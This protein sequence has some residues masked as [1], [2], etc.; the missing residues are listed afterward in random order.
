[1]VEMQPKSDAALLREYVEHG[2]EAPL[3]EIAARHTDLVY[4]AAW[5]QV[6]SPDWARDV[7]QGVFTDLVRKAT[8]LARKANDR[9]SLAGWLYGS[10]R[11]AALI[12]KSERTYVRCYSF[13]TTSNFQ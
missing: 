7:A 4:A 3:G 10:T 6:G 13:E 1:M 8:V 9:Q 2:A 11:H 5:R 12:G